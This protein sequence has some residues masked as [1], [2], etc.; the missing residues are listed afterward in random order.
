MRFVAYDDSASKISV[1]EFFEKKKD[2]AEDSE[3]RSQAVR[4]LR[5]I[6]RH[7]NE[8]AQLAD[9]VGED[10]NLVLGYGENSYTLCIRLV[11]DTVHLISLT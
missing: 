1:D 3:L 11:G 5:V 2:F 4:Y 7:P 6:S 10:F 9:Q 8:I